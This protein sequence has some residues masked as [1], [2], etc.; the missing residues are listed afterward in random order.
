MFQTLFCVYKPLGTWAEV[1]VHSY[2][3]LTHV[4]VVVVCVARKPR[5][6]LSYSRRRDRINS[7]LLRSYYK[8]GGGA[9]V[10]GCRVPFS[11]QSC[12][13]PVT[14]Y[15]TNHPHLVHMCWPLLWGLLHQM[16]CSFATFGACAVVGSLKWIM[17]VLNSQG[18][19]VWWLHHPS[20]FARVLFLCIS[21]GYHSL[22]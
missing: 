10:P 16:G 7:V 1:K 17:R 8:G 6:C 3:A 22:P 5:P 21:R 18:S 19:R 4:C 9:Q 11:D 12:F 2:H 14:V 13:L 20:S 15:G